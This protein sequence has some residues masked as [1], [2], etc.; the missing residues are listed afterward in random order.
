MEPYLARR[1]GDGWE[2]LADLGLEGAALADIDVPPPMPAGPWA[3]GS[4][5]APSAR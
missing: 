2:R 1:D 5:A 4:M 3:I